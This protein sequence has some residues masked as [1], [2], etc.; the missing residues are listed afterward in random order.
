MNSLNQ[1][2]LILNNLL[3]QN[4]HYSFVHSTIFSYKLNHI[5]LYMIQDLHFWEL[6]DTSLQISHQPI[7]YHLTSQSLK[8]LGP[9]YC[10]IQLVHD[11]TSISFPLQ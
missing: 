10:S 9:S 5:P 7:S 8:V 6:Y 3:S 1:F 2:S 11:P 4:Q